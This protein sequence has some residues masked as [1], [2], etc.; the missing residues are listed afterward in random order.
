MFLTMA[1]PMLKNTKSV[2][3]ASHILKNQ[4][5]NPSVAPIKP[6]NATINPNTASNTIN[7]NPER[8]S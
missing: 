4:R 8:I 2:I 7:M 3:P 1:N 5:P 6:T